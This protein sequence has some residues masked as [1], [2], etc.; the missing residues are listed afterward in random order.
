M[1]DAEEPRS[2]SNTGPGRPP[3]SAEAR[4]DNTVQVGATRG[5]LRVEAAVTTGVLVL[6]PVPLTVATEP[7]PDGLRIVAERPSADGVTFAESTFTVYPPAPLTDAEAEAIRGAL[8]RVMGVFAEIRLRELLAE[9][10]APPDAF[11]QA[12]A[13]AVAALEF[14]LYPRHGDAGPQDDSF[15]AV[16][17][18]LYPQ[19]ES[20]AEAATLFGAEYAEP[21]GGGGEAMGRA[22]HLYHHDESAR[23]SEEEGRAFDALFAHLAAYI[24][25]YYA[26]REEAPPKRRGRPRRMPEALPQA[27]YPEIAALGYAVTDA[28][29]RKGWR[30]APGGAALVYSRERANLQVRFTL[31]TQGT[32]EAPAAPDL[33]ALLQLA[34]G[35]DTYL[36]AQVGAY[37]ALRETQVTI[38]LDDLIRLIGWQPR[39]TKERESMRGAV[40]QRLKVI[41]G[42]T[43]HGLRPGRYSD[44]D[45]GQAID[46]TSQ[47]ALFRITGTR[48]PAQGSFDP[49]QVPLEV[50]F[51]AGPFIDTHRGNPQVLTWFGDFLPIAGIP[52]EKPSGAWARSVGLALNQCWRMQ[53]ARAQVTHPGEDNALTVRTRPFTRRELLTLFEPSPTAADVLEGPNPARARTYWRDAIKRLELAGVIGYYKEAAAKLPR[54]GWADVWLGVKLDIRPGLEWQEQTAAIAEAAKRAQK[55]RKRKRT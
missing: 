7:H 1:S 8:K 52:G 55:R 51:V 39:S 27:T 40:W 5:P 28:P 11:A 41:D 47:D 36:L 35:V 22:L 38:T 29:T 3:K 44:P 14:V 45:T 34:G 46:L 54:Y 53:A 10:A 21:S 19:A 26:A 6:G 13:M 25:G 32:L 37:L 16:V 30:E 2:S 23:L 12:A 33:W 43:I 18:K 4:A 50:T 24:Q 17:R 48:L 31:P 15:R 49:E 9:K 42:L 20:D